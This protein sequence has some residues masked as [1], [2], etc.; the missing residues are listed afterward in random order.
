MSNNK[1]P[2]NINNAFSQNSPNSFQQ[3]PGIKTLFLQTGY[4]QKNGS[5]ELFALL[6]ND[7]IVVGKCGR[8]HHQ[9]W[10]SKL[11]HWELNIYCSF[12]H[13]LGDCFGHYCKFV[14]HQQKKRRLWKRHY[15]KW[16]LKTLYWINFCRRPLLRSLLTIQWSFNG[17]KWYKE[18]GK[19]WKK[20]LLPSLQGSK[21][22][23]LPW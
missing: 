11:Q 15:W 8:L 19:R 1:C 20:L 21:R 4:C 6:L 14:G 17:T 23:K 7:P 13:D 9:L 16:K 5:F 12:G 10:T 22:W 18:V 2:R 3:F